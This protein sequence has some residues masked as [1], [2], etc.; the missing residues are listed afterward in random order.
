M[1]RFVLT[2][3]AL[4]T[5]A[6][7][8]AT[9]AA[10][11][12]PPGAAASPRATSARAAASPQRSLDAS[13]TQGMQNAGGAGS[14]YVLDLNTA[15][16]LFSWVADT[17]RL[18]ASVEK[19]YTTSTALLRFGANA[20]LTTGVLGNGSIDRYDGFHG[21][22]WLRGGG[23]PTFGSS[24]FDQ[25]FYGTGATVGRLAANLI[26]NTGIKS[27]HGRI[28][29]DDTYFDA[30]RGTPPTGF[31]SDLTDVEG[32]LSALAYDRGFAT[33]DGSVGQSRPALYATQQF[34]AALQARGVKVASNTAVYT[35][36]APASAQQLA[37]VHS[38][39]IAKLIQLTNTPSDNYLAEMLLKGLGARFG[40]AGTTS[41]GA[42]VVRAELAGEFGIHTQL[43]DGSGLSRNDS[44]S[45]VQVVS[46]LRQLAG[47]QD[48]FNSLAIGGETGTLQ[49]SMNGT[50]A[51]GNCH[52]KTGTLHDVANLVGYCKARDGHTLAF[53]FLINSISDPTYVHSVE[54]NQMAVAVASYNG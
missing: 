9:A 20:T 4:I 52:G 53:A 45:P 41:A 10:A 21:T 54:A 37:A 51:Q 40:G 46:L 48:F 18:P 5:L 34:V 14:A 27:I 1:R 15:H 12:G 38:P 11:A 22:L 2:R 28:V 23:D 36:K 3:G 24:A 17:G 16:S 25:A 35:G 44:T 49:D 19:L 50:V 30:L 39:R 13:L 33:S 7:T 43:E 26:R 42:A 31:G 8:G 6:A 29:G 32:L 47:N